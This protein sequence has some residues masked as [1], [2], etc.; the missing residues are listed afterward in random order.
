[1]LLV[2]ALAAR[3]CSATGRVAAIDP[4]DRIADV[5]PA[6]V[7]GRLVERATYK[8]APRS[9]KGDVLVEHVGPGPAQYATRLEQQLRVRAREDEARREDQDRCPTTSNCRTFDESARDAGRSP[10]HNFELQGRHRR[11]VREAPPAGPAS[12]LEAELE[13]KRADQS[14]QGASLF[15][16]TASSPSWNSRRPRPSTSTSR[17]TGARSKP[18][19]P[20]VESGDQR[21]G[22]RQAASDVDQGAARDLQAKIE[23]AKSLREEARARRSALAEPRTCTEARDQAAERQKTR[24]VTAP[25][26]GRILA[27]HL[28]AASTRRTSSEAGQTR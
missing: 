10:A 15:G 26:D 25:R 21:H 2:V 17:A 4:L 16:T 22:E 8:R 27:A 12:R 6:P 13:Q 24:V 28:R 5:M 9:N 19:A 7:T 14:A 18:H 3:T 23:S 1:M 11:C 20:K